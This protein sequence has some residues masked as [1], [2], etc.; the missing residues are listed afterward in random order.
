[1][2]LTLRLTYVLHNEKKPRMELQLIVCGWSRRRTVYLY[3]GN[4][5][6][7]CLWRFVHASVESAGLPVFIPFA[8]V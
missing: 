7:K 4:E 5:R 2:R 6:T 8:K 3:A 1:M